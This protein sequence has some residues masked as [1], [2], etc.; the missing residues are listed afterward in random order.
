MLG[1]LLPI[2]AGVKQ[3]EGF[4][5]LLMETNTLRKNG[6]FSFIG[7]SC[8][9]ISWNEKIWPLPYHSIWFLTLSGILGSKIGNCLAFLLIWFIWQCVQNLVTL[10]NIKIA[11]KWMFIPLKMALIGIDPYPYDSYWWMLLVRSS[12]GEPIHAWSVSVVATLSSKNQAVV[13]MRK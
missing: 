7:G 9:L 12:D 8:P 3:I 1:V 6:G 4:L 13:I 5:L 2:A 11:G 10:V